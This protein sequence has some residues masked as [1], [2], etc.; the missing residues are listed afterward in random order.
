LSH[1]C[2]AKQVFLGAVVASAAME[3]RADASL[4]CVFT[5]AVTWWQSLQNWNTVCM[6]TSWKQGD[7]FVANFNTATA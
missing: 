1:E 5:M 6:Q 3:L 7:K 2:A 4:V